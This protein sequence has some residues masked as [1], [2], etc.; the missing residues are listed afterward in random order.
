MAARKATISRQTSETSVDVT[1]DLDWSPSLGLKQNIEVSTGIGFL[2]HVHL[3]ICLALNLCISMISRSILIA[4][5]Y[6]CTMLLQN[7]EASV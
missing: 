3:R 1:L 5:P 4:V 7:T 6:R 2:D